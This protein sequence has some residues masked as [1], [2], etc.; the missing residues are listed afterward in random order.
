[1]NLLKKSCTLL[2]L[3]IL[4]SQQYTYAQQGT[5][6]ELSKETIF[7][8]VED[9][10]QLG[11]D[12]YFPEG[13]GPFPTILVR[14]PYNI[15]GIGT[16][17]EKIVSGFLENGWM[18]VLQDTRGKF[19]SNGEYHPF[20]HER[21][22]GLATVQWIRSQPWCNGKIAGW[23]GSYVGYTQWAIAD[24][25]DVITPTVTSANMYELI[26]PDGILSLATGLN[27]GLA[28][29]ARTYNAV[30]PEK[31]KNSYF[32]LPLSVSDDSAVKQIG[33]LDAWLAHPHEDGYWGAMNHRAAITCPV[34]TIAG[35][36]DI[37]LM[38]QIRDFEMMEPCRHPDSRLMIGPYAHGTI[39]IETDFGKDGDLT[40][41]EGDL[42]SAFIKKHLEE[43]SPASDQS[44][45]G[46]PY[47]FFIM[48]RNQWVDCEAWPP[49]NSTPTPF[50]LN[51]D[52]TISQDHNP[53]G[54]VIEYS[55]DPLDPYPSLGGT[56]LGVGVGPAYQ[57]ANTGRTDQVVFESEALEEPL[58]L[59]GPIDATI[60]AETDAP[61]TDFYI[62]LQEV[63]SDGKIINIQ[64]GGKTFYSEERAPWPKKLDISVWATGYQVEAGHKLRVVISSS[65][66]PRFNRNLNSGEEIFNAQNPRIA[67]QKIY[68]GEKYPAHIILPVLEID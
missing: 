57:N 63:R 34:L 24:V 7:I 5:G 13:K 25:L 21:P 10:I 31:M 37:F 49:G 8:T 3:L 62:S 60:Y 26:Y 61:T 17:G 11:T 47:S 33:F 54:K 18:A 45:S 40:V 19:T 68:F 53:T 50:Y 27:W 6:K 41:L 44:G 32:T 48:H 65:L 64:E 20:R 51:P 2:G 43:E 35:W 9:S 58:V 28:N 16:Y 56:F 15:N 59:L 38:A 46:K 12:L 52:G 14:M 66:F 36:Y 4:L 55:Y 42:V 23:G 67:R 29:G 39:T 30:D 1:M 22:D